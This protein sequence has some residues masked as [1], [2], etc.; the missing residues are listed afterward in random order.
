[1]SCHCVSQLASVGEVYGFAQAV[2][3]GV[4]NLRWARLG[5]ETESCS[6]RLRGPPN[7]AQCRDEEKENS[8]APFT[9]R[10]IRN[11]RKF[12]NMILSKSDEAPERT[13][14]K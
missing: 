7:R 1:M 9:K 5:F 2:A 12:Q 3:L 13:V 14:Q 11:A 4:P 10:R 6:R 8:G